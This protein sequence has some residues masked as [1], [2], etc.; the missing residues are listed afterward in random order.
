MTELSGVSAAGKTQLCLQLSLVVQM[1]KSQGGLNGGKLMSLC[2]LF[3]QQYA[4]CCFVHTIKDFY[5][6]VFVKKFIITFPP[7]TSFH[8]QTQVV[9][10]YSTKSLSFSL[11]VLL[12]NL[13][14][15]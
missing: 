4:V 7:M 10:K 5:N 11:F 13:C 6:F 8:K 15:Y 14:V 9:D 12:G 2:T 3:Q 1:A